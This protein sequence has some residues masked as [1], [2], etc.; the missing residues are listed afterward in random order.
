MANC[1]P[2]KSMWPELVRANGDAAATVIERQNRNVNAIVVREGSSVTE[3]LR[4]DRVWV[5]VNA[6]NVVVRV[7]RI[8]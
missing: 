3:D 6:S 1:P 7:P 2:G 4:C 5:W 8:G